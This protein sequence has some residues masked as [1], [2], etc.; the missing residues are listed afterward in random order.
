MGAWETLVHARATERLLRSGALV[1]ALY[2]LAVM[3]VLGAALYAC[4]APQAPSDSALSR[5]LQDALTRGAERPLDVL[6]R[7][8][9][10]EPT[11]EE[12]PGGVRRMGMPTSFEERC[13][14]VR[15]DVGAQRTPLFAH[16][17]AAAEGEATLLLHDRD[18]EVTLTVPFAW[19]WRSQ[20]TQAGNKQN[21]ANAPEVTE[22]H[23]ARAVAGGA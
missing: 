20:C 12:F 4:L 18:N 22:V 11:S 10:P 6:V 2:G 23:V 13:R 15:V 14:I 21:C 16:A 7:A 19:R 1:Q 8:H 5:A 3:V 17:G 9:L